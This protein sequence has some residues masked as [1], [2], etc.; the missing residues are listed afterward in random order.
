M[1]KRTGLLGKSRDILLELHSINR[2][3]IE[4]ETLKCTKKRDSV[5][6]DE[7]TF[8]IDKLSLHILGLMTIN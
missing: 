3:I 1:T 2:S 4:A 7:V 8:T 6:S 5:Y